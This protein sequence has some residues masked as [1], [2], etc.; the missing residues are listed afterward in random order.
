VLSK[1]NKRTYDMPIDL[2][3]LGESLQRGF[4]EIP[5]IA[6]ALTLLAGPTAA[7]I[8]YR[9]IG[10][11][12]RLPTSADLEAN[13]YWVCHDCRSVNQLRLSRCYHCSLARDATPEI[14]VIVDAPTGPPAVFEVPAGSPFAALGGNLDPG[15]MPA[16]G[17]G[18]PVMAEAP[19]WSTGVPVGPGRIDRPVAVPVVAE[20]GEALLLA[21]APAGE[22]TSDAR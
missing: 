20:G 16:P 19:D 1:P 13:P 9:L 15:R 21:E 17:P 7:L 8:G 10:A 6:I 4:S 14:E 2:N 22:A 11:A 5:P 18:V 3:A 12:R